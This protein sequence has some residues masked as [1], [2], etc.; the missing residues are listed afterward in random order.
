MCTAITLKSIEQDYI[1]ARNMDFSLEL[2]PEMIL[3]PRNY[4]L[5][6]GKDEDQLINHYAFMGLAKKLDSYMIADGINEHGIAGAALY[7]KGFADYESTHD[8]GENASSLYPESVMSYMLATCNS[9]EAV[10][11]QFTKI[12]IEERNIPGMN[13]I[14]PLHWIFQDAE[15]KGII[16]EITKEGLSIYP[17]EIGVMANSPEYPWHLTHAR[18]FAG[19]DI[20]TSK[21]RTVN[22]YEYNPFGGDGSFGLPGDYTSPSRFVR[23]L[24]NLQTSNAEQTD[25]QSIIRAMHILGTVNIPKGVIHTATK[26]LDYTQYSTYIVTNNLTYC[27]RMYDDLIPKYFNL[28]DYTL[29]GDTITKL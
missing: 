16:V 17:N 19:L 7:F 10:S 4:P 20:T 27:Y 29:D 28:K 14:P 26:A 21:K 11:D 3:F 18:L 25:T 12:K 1:L 6:Y 22:G 2:N 9:L 23:A 8:N 15:G 24:F 5:I 13:I